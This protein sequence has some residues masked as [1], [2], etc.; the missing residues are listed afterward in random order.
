MG[1]YYK[2]IFLA[3]TQL[4]QT[5]LIRMWISPNNYNVSCKIMTHC[6]V[7]NALMGAVEYLLSKNGMFYK[8]RIVW[9]GDYAT[10]ENNS[11][12]NLYSM[13]QENGTFQTPPIHNT[14]T[15]KY[16][17]N[18][19]KKLFVSKFNKTDS[20]HPLPLLVL[21]KFNNVTNADYAGKNNHLGGTWA[22]DVISV[23]EHEPLDY[24]ELKLH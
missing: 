16:I 24:V 7:G 23:E 21:D 18:H 11:N 1:Q 22:R 3:D 12:A 14:T 8:S 19:S 10:K 15:Y 2:I 20:I 5:E 4:G 13:A 17:V 9:A 6:Y